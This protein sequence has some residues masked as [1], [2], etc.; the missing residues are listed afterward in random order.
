[1]RDMPELVQRIVDFLNEAHEKYP[2]ETDGYIVY[3]NGNDGTDF[4]WGCNE[5][6]CEFGYSIPDGSCWAFKCCV[7]KYGEAVIYC[8]PNGESHPVDKLKKQLFT[9]REM[10]ELYR[11][12]YN[13]TDAKRVWDACIYDIPWKY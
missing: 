5:R 8:Y 9:E 7:S 2:C 3:A 6:L 10:N 12:M 1:M 13:S 11:I 4:D